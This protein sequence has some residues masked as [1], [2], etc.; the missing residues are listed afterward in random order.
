MREA[1][2]TDP[3]HFPVPVGPHGPRHGTSALGSAVPL[4]TRGRPA[5]CAV[6]GV[7]PHR[8]WQRHGRHGEAGA[9]QR[10]PHPGPAGGEWAAAVH[11]VQDPGGGP[12][13]GPQADPGGPALGPSRQ[14]NPGSRAPS[15]DPKD[16]PGGPGQAALAG[17]QA[18][19][20]RQ[21]PAGPAPG[22]PATAAPQPARQVLPG[23]RDLPDQ[24]HPEPHPCLGQAEE[25]TV[26]KQGPG[27]PCTPAPGAA[28]VTCQ[29][30]GR[31]QGRQLA[32][33]QV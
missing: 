6:P 18:S 2:S 22:I 14:G 9:G 25:E 31:L 12:A 30:G 32:T 11:A 1:Q 16:I 13:G 4:G 17:Q 29:L 24:L 5:G 33:H 19:Q 15:A 20:Y 7:R 21:G 10:H 23:G 26:T 27:Q 8:L 3:A 28:H